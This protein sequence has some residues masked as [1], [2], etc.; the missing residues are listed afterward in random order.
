MREFRAL[1][2]RRGWTGNEARAHLNKYFLAEAP[3]AQATIYK[4]LDRT[5]PSGDNL[6][7]VEAFVQAEKNRTTRQTKL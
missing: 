7:A 2:R 5:T 3:I 6:F 1:V 4:W